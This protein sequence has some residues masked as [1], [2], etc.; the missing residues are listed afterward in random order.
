[1]ATPLFLCNFEKDLEMWPYEMIVDRRDQY[2][3]AQNKTDDSNAVLELLKKELERRD[4]HM[5]Y[6]F[7]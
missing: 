4:G 3:H 7:R 5:I 2:Q 1:M 6:R